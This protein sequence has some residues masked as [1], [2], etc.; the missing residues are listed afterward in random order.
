MNEE[1]ERKNIPGKKI[2]I[3]EATIDDIDFLVK[4]E[5]ACFPAHRCSSRRCLRHSITSPNQVVHIIEAAIDKKN[6][7]PAGASICFLHKFSMRIYSIAILPECRMLLLGETLMDYLIA[8]ADKRGFQKISLEADSDNQRLIN[9]YRKKSFEI[10]HCLTDYYREGEAA[11]KMVRKPANGRNTPDRI[12]IVVDDNYRNKL[13]IPGLNICTASE[14]LSETHYSNSNRFHVVNLCSSYRTH[15]M[16]YYVSLLASARNQRITPSVMT[17]K[18]ASNIYIAQS[19]LDEIK[20]FIEEKAKHITD[21]SFELTVIMGKASTKKLEE[22]G[23]KL[24][25][26]FEIPFFQVCFKKRNGW[27]LK[28]LHIMSLKHVQA[29]YPEILAQAMTE[30]YNR[31]R[32]SRTRLKNYTYDLAILVN[33]D[34]KTP[35]S[36]PVALEKF[37]KAAEN[38]GFFVEFITKADRRRICEFDALF[39]R[40]T[41]AIESHTYAMSRHAYTEGL[42]VIDDPWSILLCSNKVYLQERLANACIRQPQGWLLTRKNSTP[43]F[44]SSLPL[45]LVLK[46]PESSFSQGVFKVKSYA[47]LKEKLSVMF[48]GNALVIAQEYLVSEYDWRIGVLDNQALFACK[49]YMADGHWQIYNWLS[50]EQTQFS[51]NSETVAIS[52]VPAQVVQAAVKAASLIGNGFYGV[53]LKEINGK[54]YVIEVNDNPNVDAGVEDTLLGDDLYNRIIGSI[55][56]R[57]ESER[58]QTRYLF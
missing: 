58:F 3:R 43:A 25:S 37:R 40:E 39:I 50:K 11:C 24:F 13:D 16:G 1:N 7:I 52:E 44:L 47:E 54:V 9:W 35:P 17:V 19:L 33:P 53:D 6:K 28:K 32:Y 23:K 36:C 31:K 45:P 57:I 8:Y 5:K 2:A 51:G 41:T 55:H 48:S 14:Y 30:Y 10:T 29:G 56:N 12:I 4:L 42:V 38:Q 46:L 27:Q 34:E 22:L 21:E 26:I 18:D 20:D 49:Y 15:S